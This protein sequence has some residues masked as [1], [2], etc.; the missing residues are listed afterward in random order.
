MKYRARDQK[1]MQIICDTLQEIRDY[2]S[3]LQPQANNPN[4]L[5][6]RNADV[7]EQSYSDRIVKSAFG[8]LT[9]F[10]NCISRLVPVTSEDA[11]DTKEELIRLIISEAEN[12][13]ATYFPHRQN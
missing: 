9:N 8:Y 1:C 13:R 7:I 3:D 12:L 2:I 6:N 10:T 11:K 5:Y 4:F